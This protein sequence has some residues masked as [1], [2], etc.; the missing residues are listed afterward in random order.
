MSAYFESLNRRVSTPPV[1]SA[2]APVQV[3][4][5][6]IAPAPNRM[7]E[8]RRLAPGAVPPAYVR[9]RERL[10]VAAK[11][12]AVKSLVFSGCDGG[13][14]CTELVREFAE[15]LASSGLSV[16]LVD[17]DLRTAALTAGIAPAGADLAEL[18]RTKGT[19][20][21]SAWG[22]GRLAVV[23]SEGSVTDKE[24]FLRSPDL[25]AWLDAQRTNFD[26]TLVDSAPIV[27]YSD[28]VLTSLFTDGLVL[29][30]RSAMT[31]GSSLARARRE[32]ER[33]GGKVLGVVLNQ[34]RDPVPAAV[35]RL[36]P[37]TTE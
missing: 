1:A 18:V 23:G 26:F 21:A 7:A 14:G 6:E 3:R 31:R 34:Y 17:G 9:L 28:G 8:R 2:P 12:K 30:A 19:P 35:R 29:V 37:L 4:P 10:S 16:L 20:S 27:R 33:A 5:A 11:G 15:S 32:V 13:E 25:A 22:R 24:S 36:L